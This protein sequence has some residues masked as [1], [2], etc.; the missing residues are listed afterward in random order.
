MNFGD[1]GCGTA[2]TYS[3]SRGLYA[4]V[5]LEGSVIFARP[6]VNHRFYGRVVSSLELLKGM[7]FSHPFLAGSECYCRMFREYIL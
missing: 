7:S 5:S 3:Q 4:G 6:D 2:V 1:G